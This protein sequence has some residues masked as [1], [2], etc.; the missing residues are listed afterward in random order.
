MMTKGSRSGSRII[1]P[2]FFGYHAR[3]FA[4]SDSGHSR[5]NLYLELHGHIA[6]SA[7]MEKIS[8]GFVRPDFQ[9]SYQLEG[10]EIQRRILRDLGPIV[11]QGTG[12]TP[13]SAVESPYDFVEGTCF[14]KGVRIWGDA[15]ELG[16]DP[17]H[18]NLLE[19][20]LNESSP[21]D[22]QSPVV[23]NSH[24]VDTFIQQQVLFVLWENW[25]QGMCDLFREKLIKRI[26]KN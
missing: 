3:G 19:G 2:G 4:P 13:K 17:G 5:Y 15:T 11:R 20:Q 16:I 8:D 10:F 21:F 18:I 14:L 23:Y 9:E 7:L 25:A 6:L 12:L 1:Y 24:N 26:D 22:F